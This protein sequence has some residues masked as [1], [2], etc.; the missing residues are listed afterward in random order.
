L[1]II[2][3]GLRIYISYGLFDDKNGYLLTNLV[4]IWVLVHQS[5]GLQLNESGSTTQPV[6]VSQDGFGFS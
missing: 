4:L 3:E 2:P 5:G 6:S 1:D